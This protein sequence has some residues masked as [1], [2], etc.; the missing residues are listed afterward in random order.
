MNSLI[1]WASLAFAEDPAPSFDV[2]GPPA[3]AVPEEPKAPAKADELKAETPKDAKPVA[4]AS[5]AD[6]LL[7]DATRPKP[8][9]VTAIEDDLYRKLLASEPGSRVD[10]PAEGTSLFWP[11]WG[12]FVLV[13]AGAAWLYMKRKGTLPGLGALRDDPLQVVSRSGFGSSGLMLVDVTQL[14]GSKRRL[15]VG[16]G[17]QPVLV[18]DLGDNAEPVFD[19]LDRSRPVERQPERTERA[20]P[21]PP[22][23]QPDRA[24]RT[25]RAAQ[26]AEDRVDGPASEQLAGM[27]S[28]MQRF[29]AAS[30]M[31][32]TRPPAAKAPSVSKEPAD[33]AIRKEKARS[34]LDDVLAQRGDTPGGKR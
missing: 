33:P 23:P 5:A 29:L 17:S 10:A 22:A 4:K 30:K 32:G 12:A 28:P 34:L 14:D 3:E 9:E 26:A 25:E 20:R 7:K 8:P 24:K 18:A 15:L 1:L 13:G 6:E 19:D 21:E 31:T 27:G 2:P 16:M 11:L